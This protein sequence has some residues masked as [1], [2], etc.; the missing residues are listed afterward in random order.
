MDVFAEEG[1]RTLII[2]QRELTDSAD[3]ALDEWLLKYQHACG[4][5]DEL[6]KQR[7]GRPNMIDDLCGEVEHGLELLGATA[8]EDKLQV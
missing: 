5:A 8:I 6:T 4:D 1:L 7:E 2:A 3:W